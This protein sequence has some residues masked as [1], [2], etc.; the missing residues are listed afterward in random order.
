MGTHKNSLLQDAA[1]GAFE[2]SPVPL[3]LFILN[4]LMRNLHTVAIWILPL[5]AHDQDAQVRQAAIEIIGEKNMQNA[6]PIVR[7]ALQ[8]PDTNVRA[9]AAHSM[10]QFKLSKSGRYLLPLLQDPSPQVRAEAAKALGQ[11]N[12]LEYSVA[13]ERCLQDRDVNVRYHAIR[14]LERVGRKEASIPLRK[15][16]GSDATNHRAAQH[17]LAAVEKRWASAPSKRE[18]ARQEL[19]EILISPNQPEEARQ[20][21]KIALMRL[22]GDRMIQ[23]LCEAMKRAEGPRAREDIAD[24]LVNLPASQELQIA[25]IGI[26]RDPNRVIRQKAFMALGAKANEQA[27]YYLDNLIRDGSQPYSMV[28]PED[29]QLAYQA[30]NMIHERYARQEHSKTS[31]KYYR[32]GL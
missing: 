30:K 26:M 32:G 14:A 23:I 12:S 27:Y 17:A 4:N 5:A 15:L 2:F 21:A 19:A 9:S 24:V 7:Q 10:G 31:S 3:R 13:L 29:V 11:L 28:T 8:D 6:L 1:R 25:L 18:Q 16:A 20:Q 22:R